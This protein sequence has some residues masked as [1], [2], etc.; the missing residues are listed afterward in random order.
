MSARFTSAGQLD[1]SDNDPQHAFADGSGYI[2]TSALWN[3]VLLAQEPDGRIV[4]AGEQYGSGPLE[5]VRYPANGSG[6]GTTLAG[7]GE[8]GAFSEVDAIAIQPG[9]RIVVAGVDYPAA[10]WAMTAFQDNGQLDSAFMSGVDWSLSGT[11]SA[12]ALQPDGQ[13]LLAGTGTPPGALSATDAFFARFASG[14]L[15]ALV[16]S[17][18]PSLLAV[19]LEAQGV[20]GPTP[21]T[22][23]TDG[24]DV[25]LNGT[26]SG[27]GSEEACTAV[28][29]WQN[30][31][32]ETVGSCN[33]P[34]PPGTNFSIPAQ[35]L[36]ADGTYNI[37]VTIENA[38]GNS[39]T[40]YIDDITYNNALI[41]GLSLTAQPTV[42][43]GATSK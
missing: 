34:L 37:S 1:D 31:I 28:I 35:Q 3:D 6:S 7:S 21:V 26:F 43:S 11:P 38:G 8:S 15:D 20:S 17:V 32:D 18:A 40:M 42:V 27:A 9:G 36:A 2:C 39:N 5:I 24:D 13:I 25:S 19:N 14:G 16:N 33:Y 22:A 4:L 29:G 23:Y 12:M 41:S 10:H 30:T